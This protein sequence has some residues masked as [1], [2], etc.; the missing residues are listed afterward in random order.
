MSEG[1]EDR[2]YLVVEAYGP[3]TELHGGVGLQSARLR[4]ENLGVGHCLKRCRRRKVRQQLE[5]SESSTSAAPSPEGQRHL[6]T[7]RGRAA[8][9]LQGSLRRSVAVAAAEAAEAAE[10]ADIVDTVAAPRHIS[11]C[12]AAPT[13][14]CRRSVQR[15]N[16]AANHLHRNGTP[17]SRPL[18]IASTPPPSNAR[19]PGTTPRP[20]PFAHCGCIVAYTSADKR[21]ALR[22]LRPLLCS[23]AR[24][25]IALLAGP[26]ATRPD[27]TT[28]N[29]ACTGRT[30]RHHCSARLS[31]GEPAPPVRAPAPPICAPATLF[32]LVVVS[33]PRH[34]PVTARPSVRNPDRD[35]CAGSPHHVAA[36]RP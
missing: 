16:H 11:R 21:H 18:Q 20:G 19:V 24:F 31:A 10:A 3:N 27:R 13:L 34:L 32:D 12:S 6:P 2:A 14:C 33:Q 36:A 7:S 28:P 22:P 26:D 1:N 17:L 23:W 15:T 29:R 5:K 9:G 8:A 25:S 4:G 35:I 30:P